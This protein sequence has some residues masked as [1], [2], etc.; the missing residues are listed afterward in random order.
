MPDAA[1]AAAIPQAPAEQE[2]TD[3]QLAGAGAQA[4]LEVPSPATQPPVDQSIAAGA[5]S[6]DTMLDLPLE[7]TVELGGTTLQLGEALAL[8]PGSILELERLPGEPLDMHI[9]GRLV[10][11]G[12][13]VVVNDSL[14]LRITEIVGR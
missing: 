13:V 6:L 12:E 14:G 10:A 8:Q 9:N 5:A 11:R 7:V 1:S 4:P 2:V 3:A